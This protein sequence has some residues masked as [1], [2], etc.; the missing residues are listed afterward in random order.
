MK[1]GFI[2]Y[3][4]NLK[5]QIKTR[6]ANLE[7]HR[8]ISYHKLVSLISQLDS[9]ELWFC[10]ELVTPS[11]SVSKRVVVVVVVIVAREGGGEEGGGEEGGGEGGGGKGGGSWSYHSNKL[12]K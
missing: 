6:I 4:T 12:E 2:N 10:H 7:R 9:Q 5:T 3:W 11:I 8:L 1:L